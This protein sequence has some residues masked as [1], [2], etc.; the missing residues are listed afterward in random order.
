MPR[1]KADAHGLVEARVELL[2][3]G[4]VSCVI[5]TRHDDRATVNEVHRLRH[6][7]YG[8]QRLATEIG[9][10]GRSAGD[11][12]VALRLDPCPRDGA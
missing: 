11:N 1:A 10:F 5:A 6:R 4:E 3:R 8:V 7:K 2:R 9:L 12:T